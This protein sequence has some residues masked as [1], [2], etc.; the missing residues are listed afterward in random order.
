M[1][2]S[3]KHR[4]ALTLLTAAIT[5]TAT[6]ALAATSATDFWDLCGYNQLFAEWG[7]NTPTGAG[8]RVAVVD[9]QEFPTAAQATSWGVNIINFG[10]TSTGNHGQGCAGVLYGNNSPCNAKFNGV[11]TGVTNAVACSDTYFFYS[12]VNPNQMPA[13]APAGDPIRVWSHSYINPSGVNYDNTYYR[14]M[15]Y[16]VNRDQCS[17][18]I[19]VQNS[20]LWAVC[21]NTINVGD[22]GE[23]GGS[24][25]PGNF[26]GA[27]RTRI[28]V[29]APGLYTSDSVPVVGTIATALWGMT[30]NDPSNTNNPLHNAAHPEAIKAILMAGATKTFQ[31]FIS[32]TNSVNYNTWQNNCDRSGNPYN[33]SHTPT[34]PLDP[35]LGTG[36]ANIYNS[37]HIMAAGQ[38][39]SGPGTT[40][41]TLGWDYNSIADGSPVTYYFDVAPGQTLSELSIML[42]WNRIITPDASD[43]WYIPLWHLAN[44]DLFLYNA[45]GDTLGSLIDS[46]ISVLYNDEYIYEPTDLPAGRYAI[47]VVQQWYSDAD[48]PSTTY[49][50]A[51]TGNLTGSSVPEPTTALLLFPA[52]TLLTRRRR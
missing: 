37:A 6:H 27:G 10:T 19:G 25:V 1:I 32:D 36:Q 21:Y 52:L 18:V 17:Q 47:Q 28:D 15:D 22:I 45:D 38:Q 29:V 51:W 33:F 39:P 9:P 8:I 11:G 20:V 34:D 46:S 14:N 43:S 26:D 30:G 3:R 48:N 44:L 12:Y 7:P 2:T 41:N 16:I 31:A 5:A 49:A 42:T 24:T 50:I 40:A 13:P 23:D 35:R 4:L